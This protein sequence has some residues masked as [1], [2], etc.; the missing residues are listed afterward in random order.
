MK[1][2]IINQERMA[3]EDIGTG[4]PILFIHPPGMGRKV[5]EKQKPLSTKF[6][7][8]LPDLVGQGDSSFHEGSEVS[9]KRFSEDLVFLMDELHINSCIIFGYSAGG[10]ISQY[11]AIH[12]PE[13]VKALILS[14]AY[15]NVN[16]FIFKT[17]HKLGIYAIKKNKH[18]ISSV[19][20]KSHTKEKE[21]RLVLKEHM[22]KS[23]AD[24]WKEFYEES[25]HFN[26]K[27]QVRNI[28]V[29]VLLIYGSKADQIN[30]HI[31]FYKKH[32]PSHQIH[33]I[34]GET[35]Q[36]PTRRSSEVNDLVTQFL[37]NS[38]N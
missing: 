9:V 31:K 26:C 23:N 37:M 30:T 16:N 24:V 5:F 10:I 17:E 22:M 27:D 25:L 33:V 19:I 18:F 21:F 7:L 15:P 36:L 6:R 29:S 1:S 13:R 32:L 8:I 11:L 35:H 34:K 4:E 2:V 20:A 28:Q 3:Y 38:L 12:F 14:G